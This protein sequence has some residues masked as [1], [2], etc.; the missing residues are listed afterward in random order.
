MNWDK[1]NTLGTSFSLHGKTIYSI[2][3]YENWEKFGHSWGTLYFT[4]GDPLFRCNLL[5]ALGQIWT[6]LGQ[7][8]FYTVEP[9]IQLKFTT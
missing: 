7:T 1:F 5:R 9:L 2:D 4:W 6:R 8:P 3:I